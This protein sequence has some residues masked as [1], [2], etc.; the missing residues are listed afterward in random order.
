MDSFLSM[1][2]GDLLRFGIRIMLM[3][4][5]QLISHSFQEIS[6]FHR[7]LSCT[8]S[9]NLHTIIAICTCWIAPCIMYIRC[10]KQLFTKDG[11]YLMVNVTL[12]GSYW[13]NP[14]TACLALFLKFMRWTQI[15]ALPGCCVVQCYY[16]CK[17][18]CKIINKSEKNV[19]LLKEFQDIM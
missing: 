9:G 17:L 16:V 15:G 12:F 1:L 18:L 8:K 13:N 2:I 14:F 10:I 5:M 3:K 11:L 4:N 19:N 6:N 7:A